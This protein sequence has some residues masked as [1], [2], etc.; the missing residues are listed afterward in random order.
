MV[1]AGVPEQ[2]A[3]AISRHNTRSIFDPYNIVDELIS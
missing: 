1:R 3:M 2:V